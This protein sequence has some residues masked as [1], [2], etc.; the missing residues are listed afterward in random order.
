VKR[1]SN[2]VQEAI[3]SAQHFVQFHALALLHRIKQSD[4]LAITKLVSTL[5]K[6]NIRAPLAQCLVIRYVSQVSQHPYTFVSERVHHYSKVISDS[7]ANE[8]SGERPFYDFLESCLRNK[9]EMVV[10]E[11]AR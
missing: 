7:T 4:R 5:T 1:W 10:L 3:N 9:S 2:E 11:A 6:T 8:S